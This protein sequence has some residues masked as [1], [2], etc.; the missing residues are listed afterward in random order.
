MAMTW[1]RLIWERNSILQSPRAITRLIISVGLRVD[2]LCIVI[3]ISVMIIPD[4]SETWHSNVQGWGSTIIG[5]HYCD[6][7]IAFTSSRKISISSGSLYIY[8]I[9]LIGFCLR[10][11]RKSKHWSPHHTHQN[12]SW[13]WWW[14]YQSGWF[15]LCFDVGCTTIIP[16]KSPQ[17]WM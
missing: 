13:W 2:D 1:I 8:M 14:W 10:S 7:S 6:G 9:G 3:W 11:I 15:Q 17:Y 12:S 5:C 4:N 16:L